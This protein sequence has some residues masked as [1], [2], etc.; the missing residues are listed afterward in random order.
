MSEL[1]ELIP[2]K[3]GPKVT[4]FYGQKHQL[5]ILTIRDIREFE[6][7]Y[8]SLSALDANALDTGTIGFLLWLGIRREGLNTDQIDNEE[9]A[10][11]LN[12]ACDLFTMVEV[13]KLG[14]K[15]EP[16][17]VHSG[18]W[19][20]EEKEGAPKKKRRK[21]KAQGE[22]KSKPEAG[23]EQPPSSEDTEE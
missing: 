23:Q 22:A 18:L 1:A 14:D 17:L 13:L 21:G 19:E 16:I 10:Y 3:R 8:G 7:E 9:W 15:I 12:Q 5:N 2:M 11:T 20:T 4:D 6:S